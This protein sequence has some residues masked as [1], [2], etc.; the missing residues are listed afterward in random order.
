M[1]R[2][3]VLLTK[4]KILEK[5]RSLEETFDYAERCARVMI[6]I[7][8]GSSNITKNTREHPFLKKYDCNDCETQFI[9]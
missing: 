4:D 7:D 8:C 2:K 9:I 5:V 6:C 1:L 3:E